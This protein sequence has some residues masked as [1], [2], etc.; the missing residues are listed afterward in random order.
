M[1]NDSK[2]RK[3]PIED[4]RRI[5]VTGREIYTTEYLLDYPSFKEHYKFIRIDITK[6]KILDDD[7]EITW[8]NN[9]TS[10]LDCNNNTTTNVSF[11]NQINY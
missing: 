5:S 4:L 10:N 1:T 2:L 7:S 9:F 6:L 11:K 3:E 8:Q